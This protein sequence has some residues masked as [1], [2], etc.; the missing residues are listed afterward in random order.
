MKIRVV[1]APKKRAGIFAFSMVFN[2]EWFIPHFLDHHRK[3]GVDYFIFYD[4]CSTDRTRELIL[5]EPDCVLMVP[6][7][8]ESGPIRHGVYVQSRI[9]TQ[10]PERE[11]PDRWGLVL[12]ADEF[13]VLPTAFSSIGDMIAHLERKQ[14]NC[15]A[16]AMVDFYPRRLSDRF[17]GPLSPF[18]GCAW[19]DKQPG[20]KRNADTSLPE[21]VPAG[22]RARL[23]AR[24]MKRHP[25]TIREIYGDSR[26]RFGKMWKTPLTKTGQGIIRNTSH[27]I[28][29]PVP[30][31]LQFALAHFK[32]YPGLDDRIH[33]S[34]TREGHFQAGVEYRFLGKALELL[35]NDPLI[36][37]GS[38]RY[39]SPADLERVGL[40]WSE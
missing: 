2:E 21:I 26:Y 5:A 8:D 4:D 28:N 16:T 30:T 14:R 39:Q 6:E 36:F 10:I 27:D 7:A 38:A 31:D 13:V 33:H 9:S 12:D 29:M 17:Y 32:F 24:L 20:F 35:S 23:L 22:V 37:D 1:K 19:F 34:T 3:L 15:A 18:Q 11:G 40:T 25:E